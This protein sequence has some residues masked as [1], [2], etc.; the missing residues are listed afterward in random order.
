MPPKKPINSHIDSPLTGQVGGSP[1]PTYK[2]VPGLADKA[3]FEP[4]IPQKKVKARFWT[5][6]QPGPFT[7]SE[8]ITAAFIAKITGSTGIRGWWSK[9]GFKDWFLNQDEQKEK[10]NFLFDKALL[11]LEQILD[12][13]D[14]NPNAKINGIKMLA[15]MTGYLGKKPVE[16]FADDDINK[17]SESQL[18]AFIEKTGRKVKKEKVVDVNSDGTSEAK[19]Q[20][21]VEEEAG[22]D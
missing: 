16:K 15:E 6:Y 13:P 9:P 3:I 21:S 17:M 4:S 8:S 12:N 2:D 19:E 18:V 22:T 5:R 14:A 1:A 10:I 20:I 11:S 7:S